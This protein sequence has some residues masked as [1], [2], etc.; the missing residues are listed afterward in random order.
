MLKYRAQ[1]LIRSGFIGFVL[2]VLVVAI[3]LAPQRL[4]S[5][6]TTIPYQAMFAE[7]GG[8]MAGN[9]VKVSGVTVG[10][11]NTVSLDRGKVLVDFSVKAAVRL[12]SETTAHIKI[13]SLLGRRVLTL[14]S[15]GPQRLDAR[16]VIPLSRTSSPYSLTDALSDLT[17][18]S[19]GTNTD[20]LNLALDT[21][22]T[23]LDRIAP[24]LAS[25]FDGLSRLSQ[26]INARNESLRALLGSTGSVSGVLAERSQQING[27]ILDANTL[28]AVL[29]DR[30]EA[31]VDLL[32][33]I[34]VVANQLSGLVHDNEAELAPTLD[35]L[36]SVTAVLQK[37]RDNLAK[38]ITGLRKVAQS[39]GESV[40]SGP[41]A[42]VTLGNLLPGS[43]LQP[44]IDWA[45]GVQPRALFP[46]PNCGE[47]GDCYS[48]KESPYIPQGPRK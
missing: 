9:E 42:S 21:L 5:L 47:T 35:R 4:T 15:A 12:G 19:A 23:T 45:F 48:R 22:S 27:L 17:T 3:G 10:T 11:V 25:T 7:A 6:A 30:R 36:N 20:Q 32:Q 34:S 40:A 1:S 24:Q 33:N 13:G 28:L 18:N 31:I 29:V 14:E 43:Y 44:F 26:I 2:V 38:S 41:V 39:N 37:N 16:T 46:L 8:L